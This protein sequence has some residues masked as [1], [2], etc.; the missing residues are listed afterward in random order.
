VVAQCYVEGVST[1]RVDDVVKSMGITGISKFQVSELAKP[2]DE[3][4]AA[5]RNRPID[6]GPYAYIWVDALTQKVRE[7]GRIVNVAVVVATGVSREPGSTANHSYAPRSTSPGPDANPVGRR[8]SGHC[9]NGPHK[10]RSKNS[11]RPCMQN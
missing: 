1:R 9:P 10:D 4:V 8:W 11:R 7:G 2:L 5:F 3:T 6:A